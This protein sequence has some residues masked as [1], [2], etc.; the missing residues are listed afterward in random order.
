MNGLQLMGNKS[1]DTR[2]LKED[3]WRSTEQRVL[4]HAEEIIN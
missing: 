3:R 4:S 2:H 1:T